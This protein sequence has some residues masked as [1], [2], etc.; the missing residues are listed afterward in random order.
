M[1]SDSRS[2]DVYIRTT[3]S[4]ESLWSHPVAKYVRDAQ[5][6]VSLGLEEIVGGM[7]LLPQK[8]AGNLL[9]AV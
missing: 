9:A 8:L 6:Q 2:S 4:V 3:T 1:L 7:D 5:T